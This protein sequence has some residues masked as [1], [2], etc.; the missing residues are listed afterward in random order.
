MIQV[1]SSVSPFAST[2]TA[3]AG[4]GRPKRGTPDYAAAVRMQVARLAAL[5]AASVAAAPPTAPE[6]IKTVMVVAACAQVRKVVR[7]CLAESGWV[8]VT[9]A[10]SVEE[11][12]SL[13]AEG[14]PDLML[15]DHPERAVLSMP[16]AEH[17]L[18]ISSEVPRSHEMPRQL[19]GLLARP[20]KGERVSSK[21]LSL[22]ESHG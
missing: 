18:L 9:E 22:L 21:V 7:D 17:V 6:V 16:G 8:R 5:H 14:A 12:T 19:V 15:V 13:L 1:N 10:A 11:A 4:Y 2:Y 3:P 20:L